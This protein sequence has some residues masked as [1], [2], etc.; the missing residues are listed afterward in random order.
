MVTKDDLFELTSKQLK[1]IINKVKEKLNLTIAG[2]NKEQL[3][4]TLMVLHKG[5]KYF[6]KK[7]LGYSGDVHI[8][9]PERKIDLDKSARKKRVQNIKKRTAVLKEQLNLTELNRRYEKLKSDYQKSIGTERERVARIK[10]QAIMRRIE[11]E[12]K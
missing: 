10:L 6:D 2:K 9:L 8:I 3:V 11:K 12:L 5:N 7:L 4:D 1:D